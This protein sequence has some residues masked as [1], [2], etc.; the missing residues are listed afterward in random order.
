MARIYLTGARGS[1][2]STVG[3]LL[4]SQLQWS[5][6]DLD[7]FL[8]S[9]EGKSIAEIVRLDG[10]QAFRN[11]EKKYLASASREDDAII[12]TGGGIVLDAENREL[13]RA[14]GHVFWLHATP[15]VLHGRLM[16]NPAHAQR[17]A[18]TDKGMLEE[19]ND[20]LRQRKKLYENACH[21]I[22][23]A[24]GD[25]GQICALVRSCAGV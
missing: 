13:M 14:C 6:I 5:F 18:L 1:G 4:A 15:E 16:R 10:W 9:G 20:I 11:L 23:N 7:A 21:W 3:K 24:E 22:I 8:C 19:I 2:K 12:A 25:A 17:P